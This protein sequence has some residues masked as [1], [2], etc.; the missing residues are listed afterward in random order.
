M[1]GKGEE[2]CSAGK[3]E[4]MSSGLGMARTWRCVEHMHRERCSA[5]TIRDV[6]ALSSLLHD[7]VRREEMARGLGRRLGRLG[8]LLEHAPARLRQHLPRPE[9]LA[10]E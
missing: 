5:L 6:L 2:M 4:D 9:H 8:R 7:M 1:A 10:S 3:G